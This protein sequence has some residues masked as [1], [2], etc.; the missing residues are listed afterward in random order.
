MCWFAVEGPS[1]AYLFCWVF[2]SAALWP[3]VRWVQNQCRTQPSDMPWRG[4]GYTVDDFTLCF[5]AVGQS[6]VLRDLHEFE[7]A[8]SKWSDLSSR[9]TN[10]PAKGSP[11]QNALMA[12]GAGQ[13]YL[14]QAYGQLL[15]SGSD[16]QDQS[17]LRCLIA[18]VLPMLFSCGREC[19]RLRLV[20]ELPT[21][22]LPGRC[23]QRRLL[24]RLSPAHHVPERERRNI[25]LHV[26]HG[27]SR[28][29]DC[30]HRRRRVCCGVA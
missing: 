4:L 6:I 22:H 5:D 7:I 16:M 11:F 19:A 24:H 18:D 9:A 29:L 17:R 15:S 13:F 23:R 27:L 28:Q 26:R 30:V 20:W 3:V 14:Y 21:G 8:T 1:P 25:Q 12:Y 2:L 10:T